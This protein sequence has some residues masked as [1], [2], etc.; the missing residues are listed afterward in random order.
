MKRQGS[1]RRTY[2][3]TV[4]INE[5]YKKK[6]NSRLK[7]RSGNH[8][9]KHNLGH[10]CFFITIF[11]A[12]ISV[13]T[14]CSSQ[15]SGGLPVTCKAVQRDF[16]IT[17][18]A[19]GVVEALRSH[20]LTAPRIIGQSLP[21]ISYLPIEG[22]YVKKD[23]VV[24]EFSSDKYRANYDDAYRQLETA[25]SDYRQ[26]EVEQARQRS[27]LESQIESAVAQAAS[28]RLQLARLEFLAS[29]EREIKELEI[30]QSE[31][32]ARKSRNKLESLT[33][34]QKEELRQKKLQI[35]QVEGK[36]K[37]ARTN[38]GRLALRT[39]VDGYVLFETNWINH[40]K[41][42]VGD[43][44]YPGMAVV[45]IPDM[46][47]LQIKLELSE[48]RVQKLAQNQPAEISL[49]SLGDFRLQGHVSQ[50][51]KVAQRV[52]RGSN[53]KTV[54]VTVLIDSTAVEGLVPGLTAS[55][56]IKTESVP[57]AVVIPLDAVFKRDSTQIIYV[58]SEDEF[59]M[60]PIELG[61]RDDNFSVVVSGLEG[62]EELA[63]TEPVSS[64]LK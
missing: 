11:A 5:T 4:G 25:R 50:I 28:A 56:I 61:D 39:P 49:S 22:S 12:L 42:N 62:G 17:V 32:A 30:E 52:R 18:E 19:E 9:S 58:R 27:Q 3:G 15:D 2:P 16:E 45:K 8:R 10:F 20:V 23:E 33:A 54:E 36:L 31:I 24:V 29:R 38:L 13:F 63:L 35:K 57:H 6:D 55:C 7:M 60:R 14:G 37:T 51:A 48:T 40:E 64:Q 21:E 44:V 46:S 34:V 26:T 47:V 59:E 41:M 53:V 1:V 43:A